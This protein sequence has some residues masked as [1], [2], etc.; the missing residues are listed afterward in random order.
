MTINIK[1]FIRSATLVVGRQDAP[2]PLDL[3]SPIDPG[4]P[5]D[6]GAPS[7]TFEFG[8][9]PSSPVASGNSVGTVNTDGSVSA[10]IVATGAAGIGTIQG[11]AGLDIPFPSGT[12]IIEGSNTD[13]IAFE[14]EVAAPPLASSSGGLQ[15]IFSLASES[16]AGASSFTSGIGTGGLYLAFSLDFLANAPTSVSTSSGGTYRIGVEY[17]L[18]TGVGRVTSGGAVLNSTSGITGQDLVPLLNIAESQ[19]TDSADAGK[20]V[21]FK[22]IQDSSDF[23]EP[24][25]LGVVS[26]A[27]ALVVKP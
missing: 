18:Q 14:Y 19:I 22:L 21:T 12:L 4:D 23:T 24:H 16:G 17:N 6:L 8:L 27:D 3:G 7:A 2:P 25:T 15:I 9:T 11:Q 13:T 10:V 1:R 5:V 20:I 26:L